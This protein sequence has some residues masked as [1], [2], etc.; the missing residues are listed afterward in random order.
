MRVI[1]ILLLLPFTQSASPTCNGSPLLCDRL[2]NETYFLTTHNSFAVGSNPAA[3]QQQSIAQQ[4]QGGVRGLALD[5]HQFDPAQ[6]TD[7]IY[8]CH[9]SCAILYAGLFSEA[10]TPIKTFLDKN[11][12]EIV[13][14]FLENFGKFPV[15]TIGRHFADAGLTS[16]TYVKQWYEPW[17]TH[18]QMIDNNQRLIV[19][20]D[21]GDPNAQYPFV[22]REYNT[23]W[24]TP[25]NYEYRKTTYSCGVDRPFE[26][27]P[28]GYPMYVMNH[29]VFTTFG[30]GGSAIP[31]PNPLIAADVNA[32]LLQIHIDNC[33]EQHGKAPNYISVDFYDKGRARELVAKLNNVPYESSGIQL[34]S[35]WSL[36][37][38]LIGLV[39]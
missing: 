18:N 4:L 17:K 5:L 19:L 22:V 8:L 28:P 3:N 7:T 39:H 25:Y 34:M 30:I 9:L 37:I 6:P 31:T 35:G 27:L 33:R 11:P 29:F 1:V 20:N 32:D 15:T 2:F 14:V 23:V 24:E 10:L 26:G 36:L 12:K 16:R 38:F 21:Y 13:T